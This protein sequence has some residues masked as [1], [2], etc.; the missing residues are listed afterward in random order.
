MIIGQW[1]YTG[2]YKPGPL[3]PGGKIVGE[4]HFS[5][6]LNGFIVEGH[7]T[8]RSADG[9]VQFLEIDGYDPINKRIATNLYADDGTRYSG[10][11]TVSGETAT[12]AV[13]F[14]AG[15]KEYQLRQAFC[16]RTGKRRKN[17]EKFR[18]TA[19][20]GSRFSSPLVHGWNPSARNET[21][22]RWR[23]PLIIGKSRLHSLTT[24]GG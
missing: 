18:R 14:L 21:R 24:D 6:A 5:F 13:K 22:V 9:T 3:G 15:G 12:W 23:K 10:V 20:L 4:Y 1:T 16:R 2:E 17:M 11:I 7:T 8:E 19:K